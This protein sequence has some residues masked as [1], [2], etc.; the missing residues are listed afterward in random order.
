[1][2]AGEALPLYRRSLAAFAAKPTLDPPRF[3]ACRLDY[4][5]ALAQ[6]GASEEAL[7]V[8]LAEA[9]GGGPQAASAARNAAVLLRQRGETDRLVALLTT[10]VSKHPED[11]VLAAMLRSVRA[12]AAPTAGREDDEPP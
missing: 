9:E 8:F 2:R 12:S 1:G 7:R 4:G 5:A 10:A 6:T 11:A 3:A